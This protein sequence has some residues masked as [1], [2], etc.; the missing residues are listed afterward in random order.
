MP[1]AKKLEPMRARRRK[2]V[3]ELYDQGLTRVA[4]AAEIGWSPQVV[5]RDLTAQG[6][7]HGLGGRPPT[8]R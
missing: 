8:E 5:T 3:L 1:Y 4:I 2:R 7:P 6:M